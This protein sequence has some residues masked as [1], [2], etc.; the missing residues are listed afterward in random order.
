MERFTESIRD[1]I[2][3]MGKQLVNAIVSLQDPYVSAS[4]AEEDHADGENME[5]VPTD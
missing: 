2:R 4:E 1:S 3:E 5:S